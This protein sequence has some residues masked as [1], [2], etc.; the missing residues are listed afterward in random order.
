[1]YLRIVGKEEATGEVAR[2]YEEGLAHMGFVMEADSCLTT[3][4][5]LLPLV[6]NFL[7]Q[8][9]GNFSL[10]LRGLAIDH[11]GRRQAGA[12]HLLLLRLRQAAGRRSRLEGKGAGGAARFPHRR[13][14]MRR[15]WRCSPMPSRSRRD[16]SAITQADIDKAPGRGLQ[17][18]GDLPTSRS[19]PRSA[20]S[21]AGFSMRSA[22]GRN[23]LSSTPI[24]RFARRLPWAGGSSMKPVLIA[25]ALLLVAADASA[26]IAP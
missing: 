7:D 26:E 22:R 17:R 21:S 12:E 16:A 15:K 5:D 14:S 3:R 23:R 8:A 6:Q 4:P 18:P 19:A 9:R 13:A 2:I 1:M 24:Q 20:A 25:V 11:P 10:G